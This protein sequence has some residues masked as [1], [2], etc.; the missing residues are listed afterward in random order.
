MLGTGDDKMKSNMFHL[1]SAARR[2]KQG[3]LGVPGLQELNQ[4]ENV[5]LLLK[6]G[7]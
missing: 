4:T 1:K 5:W 2:L 6:P 7:P 3:K